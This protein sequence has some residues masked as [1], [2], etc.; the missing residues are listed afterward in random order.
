MFSRLSTAKRLAAKVS[1]VPGLHTRWAFHG[2][3]ARESIVSDPIAGFQPLMSG[4]RGN[5]L[6]GSGT[7]FARDAKPLEPAL[8]M[9]RV[10]GGTCTTAASA[11]RTS[12][13]V[14][15]SCPSHCDP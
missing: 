10:A 12:R 4:T 8:R 1:F 13:A 3:S 5:A 15:R 2:S 9:L 6:W 14:G 7:Y 11:H